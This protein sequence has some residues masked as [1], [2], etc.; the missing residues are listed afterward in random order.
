MSRSSQNPTTSPIKRAAVLLVWLASL[1]L[2]GCWLFT[3]LKP[4]TDLT[5]FLPAETDASHALLLDE[6]R[7]GAATRLILIAISGGEAPDTRQLAAM[8]KLL[9]SNLRGNAALRRIDNGQ[10]G[11]D[12]SLFQLAQSQR[13]LLTPNDL[14][15]RLSPEGLR[16]ALQSRLR[17]LGS[18]LEL[19][20][21]DL[22]PADPTHETI[23]VLETW[24][25]ANEPKRL[26]GVWFDGAAQRV[27]LVAETVAQ[28]FDLDGQA[29]AVAAI[30]AAFKAGQENLQAPNASLLLTGPGPFGVQ[31]RETTQRETQTFSVAAVAVLLL[32]LWLIY[33]KLPL[34]L[35]G[36]LPLA[37]GVVVAL[38]AVQLVFGGI[39]GITL[40]FGVTLL[41]VAIDYPLH[42]F[43][44]RS[45]AYAASETVRQIW[46]TLRLGVLSTCIAYLTL[47]LSDFPGLAQLGLFTVV[48]LLTAAVTTRWLLPQL[49]T[50]PRS[51]PAHGLALRWQMVLRHAAVPVTFL[52]VL[53]V[54][55]LA[56]LVWG[57]KGL[58]QNDLAA[59]TPVPAELQ[60]A[61][62]QLRG[63]LGAAELRHMLLIE[64][65]EAEVV[66]QT[67]EAAAL[68]LQALVTAGGLGGFDQPARYLPSLKRQQQQ[69]AAIPAPGELRA[70]LAQAA[71][72][73]PFRDS[74]FEPFVNDVEAAR[75][76][77]ALS[78]DLYADTPMAMRLQALLKPSPGGWRALLPLQGV[79]SVDEVRAAVAG[80]PGARLLD[81][82][83]ESESMV[84][85]FR[86]ETLWRIAAAGLAIILITGW[87][88]PRRQL[89][90][91]L[92]PVL[93]T[94]LV[95]AA[96][97][98]LAAVPLTLF[99]LIS[100]MLVGGI[101][102][103]YAL[104]FNRD[105]AN[106]AD[107][108]RT[109]HAISVC[110]VSTFTVFGILALSEIPVLRAI[111]VT[112]AAGV[113]IGYMLSA[114]T[115]MG[116]ARVQPDDN[117]SIK[118]N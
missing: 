78:T 92:L 50:T 102:L 89:L 2:A 94:V 47:L 11:D 37:S 54:A 114:L 71:E 57:H 60:R 113:L 29:A 23:A 103:D 76:A 35:Y 116:E 49:L 73:L 93:A 98:R 8:S 82:K 64:G 10:R 88:L 9:A 15:Q 21:K 48:G 40:A 63:E 68:R 117:A 118:T 1:S 39:H 36:G 111:G 90:R 112:V 104:F 56:V 38:L 110:C 75:Q 19:A 51:D 27:L 80:L 84:A 101:V 95:E 61:D 79:Q 5:A 72:G 81:L 43:S 67:S 42:L 106:F 12:D 17:D 115:A 7:N 83:A 30:K 96:L 45:A 44:H 105:A 13:Y 65:D 25:P 32:L 52:V 4:A 66:L 85:G 91:V 58:W 87:G 16:S 26:H 6:L 70:N 22:L 53:I 18:A 14:A 100:L 33:R 97:F 77:A 108:T 69:Q 3:H 107:Q 28:G 34:L 59:L 41:G 46:P 62:T 55:A 20:V 99:H 24:Q 74:L 31:L 86:G 109:L